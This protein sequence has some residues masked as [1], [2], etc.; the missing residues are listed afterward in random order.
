MYERTDV[1][2]QALDLLRFP[3]A[4]M[5]VINHVFP[6][7][8]GVIPAESGGFSLYGLVRDFLDSFNN[9][10]SVPVF[11]FISGLV[12]FLGGEFGKEAYVGKL[13]KRVRTLLVPYLIL[14][15]LRVFMVIVRLIPFVGKHMTVPPGM[16]F[17]WAGLFSCYWVYDSDFFYALSGHAYN[18]W[19]N[20]GYPMVIPLWFLRDLIMVVLFSPLVYWLLRRFKQYTVLALGLIWFVVHIFLSNHIGKLT[21]AFFFFSWG[22]YMSVCGK[23]MLLVF[24]RYF[25]L[26]IVLYPLLGAAGVLSLY[27]CPQYSTAIRQMNII[28]FLILSYNLAISLLRKGRC[29]VSPFLSAGSFFVYVSHPFIIHYVTSLLSRLLMPASDLGWVVVY[30]LGAVAT[31]LM[32]LGIYYLLRRYCPAVLRV[33]TGRA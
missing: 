10:Y 30:A 12:F 33:L 24:S 11:F 4:V 26:S 22:A 17:S 20:D 25:R 9:G 23:D 29:S 5:V 6:A 31:V 27:Y 2:S 28:V 13:R 18:Y 7:F 21:T 15:S 3:L 8:L 16:H 1:R 14:I 19:Q 32:L